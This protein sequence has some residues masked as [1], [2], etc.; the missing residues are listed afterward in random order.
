MYETARPQASYLTVE[1][2]TRLFPGERGRDISTITVWNWIK[3]GVRGIRLHA[4]KLGRRYYTTREAVEEFRLAVGRKG[5]TIERIAGKHGRRPRAR[6][7]AAAKKLSRHGV[8]VR[9][10]AQNKEVKP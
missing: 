8:R 2:V 10:A 4:T 9:Q 7:A 5:E 1:Q 3:K 6:V